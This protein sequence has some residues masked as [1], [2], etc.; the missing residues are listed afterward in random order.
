MTGTLAGRLLVATPILDDPNFA[1]TVVYICFHDEN[2][3]FGLVLNRA[4]EARAS[5]VALAWGGYISPPAALFIGGPVQ[6]NSILGLAQVAE[7][8]PLDWWTPVADRVGL[9]NLA[10][11][12]AE[13][14][15]L[16]EAL[17]IFHG[18]AGWTPG[19]LEGEIAQDAWFVVNA[20]RGDPFTE[21]PGTLWQRVLR[22]Q[23]GPLAIY[24]SYPPDPT[25]N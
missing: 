12:S 7:G 13:A 20:E 22:R 25:L 10:V 21:D 3:A 14:A 18:Y 23:R 16:I 19:Q 24:G 9:V 11:S 8:A 17:R 4:E 5:D 15:P 2:G 6:P 1:R